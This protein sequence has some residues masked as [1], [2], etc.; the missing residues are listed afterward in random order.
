MISALFFVV[1]VAV[2]VVFRQIPVMHCHQKPILSGMHW[3]GPI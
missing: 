1:V 2:V 3:I